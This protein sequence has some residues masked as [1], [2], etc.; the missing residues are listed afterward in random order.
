MGIVSGIVCIR[1][2][3]KYKIRTKLDRFCDN[4]LD[5]AIQIDDR[6]MRYFFSHIF[7]SGKTDTADFVERLYNE[8]DEFGT[9]KEHILFSLDIHKLFKWFCCY[10]VIK[11][12]YSNMPANGINSEDLR[13]QLIKLFRLWTLDEG[14]LDYFYCVINRN[15]SAYELEFASFIIRNICGFNK[16]NGNKFSEI[17]EFLNSAYDDFYRSFTYY[18]GINSGIYVSSR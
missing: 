18:A 13:K 12:S 4:L 3:A 2:I 5:S 9:S 14:K 11:F 8:H 17:C 10:N 7:N 1:P 6:F 16:F 15:S